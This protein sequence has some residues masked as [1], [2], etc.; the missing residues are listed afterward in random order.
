ML[1][2]S[3]TKALIEEVRRFSARKLQEAALGAT[4]LP[5][6]RKLLDH[7]LAKTT[8]KLADETTGAMVTKTSAD[9]PITP[10]IP[11]PAG[12]SEPLPVAA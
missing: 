6:Y 10:A 4:Q 5:L 2:F 1:A 8:S 9:R 11:E 3:G 12:H 7:V